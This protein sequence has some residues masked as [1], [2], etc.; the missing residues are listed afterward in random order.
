MIFRPVDQKINQ[1]NDR[2]IR[3][4][5]LLYIRDPHLCNLK[6]GK[7]ETWDTSLIT[8]MSY[9]FQY[10]PHSISFDKDISNW[11]VS[12]VKNFS[13][14]FKN[15]SLFNQD[16]SKWDISQGACF[17]TGMFSGCRSFKQ[18]LSGNFS[19]NYTTYNCNL[20][21]NCRNGYILGT[22]KNENGDIFPSI[23]DYQKTRIILKSIKEGFNLRQ[24]KALAI[25]YPK[26]YVFQLKKQLRDEAR[27]YNFYSRFGI[28]SAV[29]A[30]TKDPIYG[31]LEYGPIQFWD[32]SKVKNMSGLLAGYKD[33]DYDIRKWDVSNVK[34]F[35]CMFMN[36]K[37]FNRDI[38]DWDIMNGIYETNYMFDGTKSFNK[39]LKNKFALAWV[40][41]TLNGPYQPYSI[42]MFRNSNGGVETLQKLQFPSGEVHFKCIDA[43][44][45][46][47]YLINKICLWLKKD[48][49]YIKLLEKIYRPGNPGYERI[50]YN[51]LSKLKCVIKTI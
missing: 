10:F 46:K 3:S 16:L 45:A 4:A 44:E 13:F 5:V 47:K 49:K 14:M 37:S 41:K 8:D 7:I 48:Y 32:V 17:L 36:C 35:N 12:N 25:G 31:L 21:K 19:N 40:T 28:R 23:N 22:T 24:A 39:I 38:S 51:F 34:N 33:F 43:L 6:F 2:G 1:I 15:Q 50:K 29:A 26:K 18:N 27:C 11:N 20:F 42:E 9:L 30:L